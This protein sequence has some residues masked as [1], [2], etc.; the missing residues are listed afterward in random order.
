[1]TAP[2]CTLLLATLLLLLSD[3]R[4]F[5][6]FP[7]FNQPS[8]TSVSFLDKGTAANILALSSI[9][10]FGGSPI[11]PIEA[12]GPAGYSSY[13]NERYHTSLS[14]PS[15]WIQKSSEL[16]GGRTLDAFVDP[17]E[18]AGEASRLNYCL[19]HGPVLWPRIAE[20]VFAR[21]AP[22]KR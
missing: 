15:E 20:R 10:Y 18:R 12:T 19:T 22:V 11:L 5:K 7:K 13:R 2:A 9:F 6:L 4:A 14:Y 8:G 3:S 17:K 16:S 21:T 1:M